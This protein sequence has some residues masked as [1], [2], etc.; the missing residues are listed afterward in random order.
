MRYNDCVP[1]PLETINGYEDSVFLFTI[2]MLEILKLRFDIANQCLGIALYGC[3]K[4][5]EY[6][7]FSRIIPL[8]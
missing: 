6:L 8:S 2:E 5:C 4:I 1:S 7:S 3:Y